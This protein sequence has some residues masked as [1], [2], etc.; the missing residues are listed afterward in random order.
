M[1][2][3]RRDAE[4]TRPDPKDPKQNF[5]LSKREKPKFKDRPWTAYF[6]YVPKG[7]RTPARS[8]RYDYYSHQ[9]RI[10]KD[11][12]KEIIESLTLNARQKLEDQG[13]KPADKKERWRKKSWIILVV[14]D[15]NYA[16]DRPGVIIRADPASEP[17]HTFYDADQFNHM[18]VREPNSPALSNVSAIYFMNHMKGGWDEN[19]VSP[20]QYQFFQ[21]DFLPPIGFPLVPDDGGTNLGPPVPPPA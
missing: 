5:Y 9:G 21:F 7:P 4:A 2:D 11:D 6:Y 17:N 15:P 10:K 8:V 19:D 20:G 12:L 14:D 3:E 18:P 13:P 1:T 16:F